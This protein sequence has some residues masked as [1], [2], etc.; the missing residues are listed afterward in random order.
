M[1]I[2]QVRLREGIS[3]R[4]KQ[5]P[6]INS[7]AFGAG[8]AQALGAVGS[9]FEDVAAVNSQI[10][11]DY[12]A[13]Q[14]K[15]ERFKAEE[16]YQRWV[17]EE[18]RAQAQLLRDGP[19]DGIGVTNNSKERLEKS[20]SDFLGSLPESAR[21]EYSGRTAGYVE[22]QVTSAFDFE[23]KAGNEYFRTTTTRRIT[24]N[25]AQ[26]LNGEIS[27][28][29]ANE[30]I[31][32]LI[33]NSDLPQLEKNQL[34]Y[35]AEQY[36]A[37]ATFQKEM[38]LAR[39]LKGTVREADGSDVVAAGLLP[40]ERGMLNA[41]SRRESTGY[42]VRYDG[43]ATGAKFTDFSKHPGVMVKRPDGRY[44]SAAGRYMF[45]LTTWNQVAAKLGLTDF[46][47]ESQDRAAI[48]LA[49]EVYNK[50]I[51]PGERT[52][53]QVLQSGDREAIKGMMGLMT[54]AEG[55]WEAFRHMNPDEFANIVMGAKGIR[56]GGT[57]AAELPNLWEDERFAIL[58]YED[59]M[60]LSSLGVAQSLKIEE[61]EL[62]QRQAAR[63]AEVEELMFSASQ[64]NYQLSDEAALIEKGKLQTEADITRFRRV[65]NAA[66]DQTADAQRVAGIL[67]NGGLLT[68][69]DNKGLNQLIGKSGLESVR[70]LDEDYARNSLIPTVARA[71]F[72]PSDTA[73]EL[74]DMILGSNPGARKYAA[75]VLGDMYLNDPY[76][77]G[78]SSGI[79]KDAEK[80]VVLAASLRPW[81][82][83]EQVAAKMA[84][85]RDPAKRQTYNNMREDAE[86]L[87][88]DNIDDEEITNAFDPS[89]F[90]GEPAM[91][92]E[93]G[94]AAILRRDMRTLFVEGY[95]LSGTQDGAMEYAKNMAAS[96]WGMTEVGGG[97]RL[98][99]HPI[100][101]YY[102]QI[103]NSHE[104]IDQQVR[105]DL[106]I[107]DGDQ[108]QLVADSRTI[109]EGALYAQ[110]E[111]KDGMQNASY[112]I[113]RQV[114]T[115]DG[116]TVVEMMQ[117]EDGNP[118]RFY[119]EV[120]PEI[121]RNVDRAA[122]YG[123]AKSELRSLISN[124]VSGGLGLTGAQSD[125]ANALL[126]TMQELGSGTDDPE[127]IVPQKTKQNLEQ[128][129]SDLEAR[130]AEMLEA[131][132]ADGVSEDYYNLTKRHLDGKVAALKK[133]LADREN[134]SET[135]D[136]KIFE[137]ELR[138]LREYR[139]E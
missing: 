59:K 66:A 56:G 38:E 6:D 116:Y 30:N 1:A 14:D 5:T 12:K 71:G 63:K 37:R 91:P 120:T 48:Y 80:M 77:I 10:N 97:R 78:R 85:Y 72:I 62:K 55:G 64:G 82:T 74:S 118:I 123:A 109:K 107:P 2:G 50:N 21:E 28:A 44:S 134:L 95:I 24:E 53:D 104:W 8:I 47:P 34:K 69:S 49:R 46:S 100:N 40:Y 81:Y 108:F 124:S 87:F 60:K 22:G 136:P 113:A 103:N 19:A 129:I 29:E 110:A 27:S 98:S 125:R 52:F 121:K 126:S 128:E 65:V 15:T 61:E 84:E 122:V 130:N 67:A 137:D 3:N 41:I 76:S 17:G 86:D 94:Q 31:G 93:P 57:G 79:S 115:P 7:G 119:A 75:D 111:N 32:R 131:F 102:P 23:Y 25:A 20:R 43:S 138:A 92:L 101:K 90:I 135:V 70:N 88:D 18:N 114:E 127:R 4:A 35:E 11:K 105:E 26:I 133:K 13:R 51:G 96:Q 112:L 139:N 45:T 73:S 58:S 9:A 99:K 117:G 68:Q 33:A 36:I 39:N 54:D 16:L 42:D 106:N 132:K 89:V 83:E